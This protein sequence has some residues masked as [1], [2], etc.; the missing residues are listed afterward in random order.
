MI[1]MEARMGHVRL[2]NCPPPC[3]PYDTPSTVIDRHRGYSS[4]RAQGSRR[5]PPLP[6]TP[7]I[8][9]PTRP[10]LA[11]RR[12]PPVSAGEKAAACAVSRVARH[13][14]VSAELNAL[15]VARW[16][17][18]KSTTRRASKPVQPDPWPQAHAAGPYRPPCVCR[19]R[20]AFA[21]RGRRRRGGGSTSSPSL[22]TRG[23]IRAPVADPL[24]SGVR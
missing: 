16:L 20:L 18:K 14:G 6:R 13:G 3:A 19:V 2:R 5:A 8:L 15:C 17:A 11:C 10:K 22:P 24:A 12:P 9:F 1:R 7:G 23:C 4:P 21:V